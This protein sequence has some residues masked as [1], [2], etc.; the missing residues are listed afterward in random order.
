MR[1]DMRVVRAAVPIAL[2]CLPLVVAGCGDLRDAA[3]LTKRSPDEFAVT[4]KAPLV[5]PPD[6]NLRPPAP[7]AAP[8]NQITPSASAEMA[9]FSD[10]DPQTIAR[11]MPGTDSMAEKLLLARAGAQKADPTIR[12]RLRADTRAVQEAN[13]SFT[14]RVLGAA[15]TPYTGKPIN[16]DHVIGQRHSTQADETKQKT[17]ESGGWFDWLF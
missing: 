11:N 10:Q 6:F 15:P 14:D 17:D 1:Y 13:T 7:G 8:T 3:G 9:L 2:M 5:V 16:P 12:S 4:T